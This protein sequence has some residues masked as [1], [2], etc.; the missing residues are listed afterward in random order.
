MQLR[1]TGESWTLQL[2]TYRGPL[3]AFDIRGPKALPPER[4]RAES[5]RRT[6]NFLYLFLIPLPTPP[7]HLLFFYYSLSHKFPKPFA[8]GG[9]WAWDVF[10][11][12]SLVLHINHLFCGISLHPHLTCWVAERKE[13]TQHLP[14]GSQRPTSSTSHHLIMQVSNHLTSSRKW[15]VQMDPGK[16]ERVTQSY[17]FYYNVVL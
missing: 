11:P 3:G 17:N 2:G 5:L 4:A 15:W 8:C 6:A 9:R 12:S 13:I 16:S 10:F 1:L 14:L 7:A